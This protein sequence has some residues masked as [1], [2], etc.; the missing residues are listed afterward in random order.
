MYK[1]EEKHAFERYLRWG[2]PIAWS[3]NRHVQH[4]IMSGVR[5]EMARYVLRMLQMTGNFHDVNV[6]IVNKAREQFLSTSSHPTSH[7]PNGSSYLLQPKTSPAFAILRQVERVIR[8]EVKKQARAS[9][10]HYCLDTH[11]FYTHTVCKGSKPL[12]AT[13]AYVEV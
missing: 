1:T 5:K 13:L 12:K 11:R 10:R 3:I 6:Q 8:M 2:V 7:Q 9:C 4:S